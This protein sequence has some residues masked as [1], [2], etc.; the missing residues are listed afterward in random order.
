[1]AE[2][3]RE[4]FLR[5][6]TEKQTTR[7]E[8]QK[9][10]QQAEQDTAQKRAEQNARDIAATQEIVD[11]LKPIFEG[12]KLA[13]TG[14]V[15]R[16]TSEKSNSKSFQDLEGDQLTKCS[17][18]MAHSARDVTFF[19][20]RSRG[21]KIILSELIGNRKMFMSTDEL[22]EH[23]IERLSGYGRDEVL[24]ILKHAGMGG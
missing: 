7:V 6:Q 21:N 20:A 14:Q 1:M 19:V 18:S 10:G 2:S 8:K 24:A 16:V 12:T 13:E 9:Q 5:T 3:D 17:I 11:V 15:I 4:R 23:V 22:K